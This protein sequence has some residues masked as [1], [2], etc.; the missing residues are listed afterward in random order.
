MTA[1]IKWNSATR[2]EEGHCEWCK[3]PVSERKWFVISFLVS[4][5]PYLAVCK[6]CVEERVPS[7]VIQPLIAT[8]I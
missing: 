6:E 1:A 7:A 4:Y 8:S 2:A 5:Q 3:E